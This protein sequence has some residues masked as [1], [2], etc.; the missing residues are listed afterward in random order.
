M[1]V[2]KHGRY[3]VE[4]I[5]DGDGPFKTSTVAEYMK[6]FGTN[7]ASGGPNVGIGSDQ[8]LVRD[9]RSGYNYYEPETNS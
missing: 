3:D 2:H 6:V 5:G 8:T 4:K 1:K 7:I 9:T